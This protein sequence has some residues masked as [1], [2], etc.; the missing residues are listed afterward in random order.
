MV[1]SACGRVGSA[2]VT[3]RLRAKPGRWPAGP[4][5]LSGRQTKMVWALGNLS[6]VRANLSAVPSPDQ[7]GP[8]TYQGSWPA[9]VIRQ[10]RLAF[11]R[12]FMLITPGYCGDFYAPQRSIRHFAKP[13]RQRWPVAFR[14]TRKLSTRRLRPWQTAGAH[15]AQSP[16][17]GAD[18]RTAPQMSLKSPWRPLPSAKRVAPR[19]PSALTM[20]ALVAHSLSKP[21]RTDLPQAR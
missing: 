3:A 2:V 21:S 19:M 6:K 9:L 14:P 18:R 11:L 8:P 4:Q 1:A 7:K 5:G 13:D 12:R 17:P 15:L 16:N 20:P 10:Q